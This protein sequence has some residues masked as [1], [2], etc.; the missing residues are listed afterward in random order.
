[1]VPRTYAIKCRNMAPSVTERNLQSKSLPKRLILV[2][3]SMVHVEVSSVCGCVLLSIWENLESLNRGVNFP[4]CSGCGHCVLGLGVHNQD[5]T[6]SNVC[7]KRREVEDRLYSNFEN[8]G[9]LYPS[10]PLSFEHFSE[11]TCLKYMWK[12]L[13]YLCHQYTLSNKVHFLYLYVSGKDNYSVAFPVH[14]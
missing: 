9:F 7:V 4:R 5:W 12:V 14:S 8:A 11:F 13:F 1:M 3:R 10:T 2:Q 6:V